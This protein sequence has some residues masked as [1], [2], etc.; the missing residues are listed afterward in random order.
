MT[1]QRRELKHTLDYVESAEK[2]LKRLYHSE[3]Q[4][5]PSLQGSSTDGSSSL[6]LHF[7]AE[8]LQPVA[9]LRDAEPADWDPDTPA[10]ELNSM[11]LYCPLF[12][13]SL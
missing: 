5:K 1:I 12:S 2:L 13:L 3:K 7:E 6:S 4:Q 11:Y 9:N 10:L 8:E